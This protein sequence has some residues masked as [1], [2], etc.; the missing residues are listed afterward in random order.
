MFYFRM[1]A[2]LPFERRFLLLKTSMTR[3]IHRPEGSF[4]SPEVSLISLKLTIRRL[5]AVSDWLLNKRLKGTC[6]WVPGACTTSTAVRPG[7]FTRRTASLRKGTGYAFIFFFAIGAAYL[8]V[9]LT[10]V[11]CLLFVGSLVPYV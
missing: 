10:S 7:K 2:Q 6:L 5:N 4:I 9:Y 3:V 1:D 8:I 11:V